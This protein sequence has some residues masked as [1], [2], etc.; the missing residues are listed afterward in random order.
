[1]IIASAWLFSRSCFLKDAQRSQPR[2]WRRAPGVSFA[3]PSAASPSSRRTSSQLSFRASRGIGQ[4]DPCP[5]QQ[6]L[7][8]R[9]GRFHRLRDLLV[10][11]R[12][13]LTQQQRGALRL[14][15]LV[16][17]R[18]ELAE[19]LAAEHLVARREAVLGEVDVHR[20][21]AGGGRPTQV[22]ERA[23]AGD[24]V[25]PGANVDL[26]IV[27]EHGVERRRED[28]LQHVLGV[29]PGP[30]HVAA[31]REQ[32]RLVTSAQGLERRVVAPPS[33]ADE[34]LIGLQPQ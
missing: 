29:L 3:S 6:G 16:D 19:A 13:H 9:D 18:D 33:K 28:L 34:A 10:G 15:E 21:D 8:R 1:M 27:G 7:D 22:V 4:G 17:V 25:Q 2:T 23:V 26:A 11:E 32:A 30:Q 12:V 20:V 14:G 24:A 5:H 31:E